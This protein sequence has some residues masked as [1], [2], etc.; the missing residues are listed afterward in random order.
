MRSAA[1]SPFFTAAQRGRIELVLRCEDGSDWTLT[2]SP[3]MEQFIGYYPRVCGIAPSEG[4]LLAFR[5]AVA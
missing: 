2:F 5:A 1:A 4:P 3:G